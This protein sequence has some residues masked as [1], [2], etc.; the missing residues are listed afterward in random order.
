MVLSEYT[1][2]GPVPER[3]KG[4]CQKNGLHLVAGGKHPLAGEEYYNTAF[5]IGP[6]GHTVFEQVKAV[7]IQFFKD[8]R[9]APIQKV[10]DS[11]WG[12]IGLAVCYDLS[13]TRVM[14]RLVDQ[15]A[16]ALIVPTM[17][18]VDWGEHQHRLHARV[19]PVR[20]AEYGLPILRVASSGISQLVDGRGHV[21]ATAPF[22]GEKAMLGGELVLAKS[23]LV[24]LDR[25]V[26]IM[27]S[28][29]CGCLIVFFLGSGV[30]PRKIRRFA[31]AENPCQ[32]EI[33]G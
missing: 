31:R 28:V 14:D 30:G 23:A 22:G 26:A 2:D 17:D 24:P 13:Y 25:R 20:A 9:P 12:R 32:P 3:I 5:V 18:V 21:W 10:W 19:A 16:Q 15:H 33:L 8:G 29:L 6:Q 1:Y 7:P 4:W 27:A 11:P